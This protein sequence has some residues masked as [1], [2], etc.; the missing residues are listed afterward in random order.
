MT[1]TATKSESVFKE[2][3]GVAPL[4]GL[5]LQRAHRFRGC[6]YRVCRWPYIPAP[7]ARRVLLWFRSNSADW[8][9]R[10]ANVPPLPR[11]VAEM[12]LRKT[13]ARQ[14]S[15]VWPGLIDR[16]PTPRALAIQTLLASPISS[17][18]RVSSGTSLGSAGGSALSSTP[19]RWSRTC[20]TR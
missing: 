6:R 4:Y 20:G 5:T 2:G 14:V 10:A 12:L 9:W 13:T 16:Y 17:S 3:V 11:L 19:V 7:H 1:L 8:P 15:R 18:A